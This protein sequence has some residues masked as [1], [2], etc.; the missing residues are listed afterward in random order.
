MRHK[1]LSKQKDKKKARVENGYH[2][3][4]NFKIASS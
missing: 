3:E 1:L 4:E 2:L